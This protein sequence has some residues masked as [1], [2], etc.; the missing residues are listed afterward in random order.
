MIKSVSVFTE[1]IFLFQ[2][3]RLEAPPEVSVMLGYSDNEDLCL[4]DIDTVKNIARD[5]MIT[6]SRAQDADLKLP[7]A[8]GTIRKI[9]EGGNT[10]PISITD[11]KK[12]AYLKGETIKLTEVEFALF[13]LL[14]KK[15]G[16][17]ATREEILDTVWGGEAN[18]G[19]INVYIHYLRE[20]LESHGEKIIISSRKHGYK[21]DEKYFGGGENA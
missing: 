10:P 11:T 14:F 13:S 6:M 7:F 3:I 5:G 19:V 4:V 9:L 1:D 20:K 2:K 21:I 18:T 16:E 17:Y 8:L 15:N 12:C